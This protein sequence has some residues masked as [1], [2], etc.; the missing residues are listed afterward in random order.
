MSPSSACSQ[1][2]SRCAHVGLVGRQY[3]R[4][5][6]R[7]RR[8]YRALAHIDVNH[9]AAL[10]DLVGFG[11]DFG[12]GFLVDGQVRHLEAV[13][14]RVELPAVIDAAQAALLIAAEEQGGTAMRAA[15]IE[16]ADPPRTVAKRDQLLA[17]EH[18]AQRIAV[19]GQFRRQT[20]R[21]PILAHQ[22]AHR[23][24]GSDAGQQFVFGCS[25]HVA[26]PAVLVARKSVSPDICRIRRPAD[27]RRPNP[28]RSA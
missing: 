20:G 1:L 6:R 15:V 14:C 21:Q 24:A 13:A 10:R 2:H 28:P 3:G 16:D 9:A 19:G 27:G 4:F 12:Q 7:Q 11:L 8:R 25:G 5:E 22:S 23:G 17:Q 18:Q 26:A